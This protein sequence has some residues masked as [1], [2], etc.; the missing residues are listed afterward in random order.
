MLMHINQTRDSSSVSYKSHVTAVT[1]LMTLRRFGRNRHS[2][3]PFRALPATT[4]LLN[5]G[6][7]RRSP[8][9]LPGLAAL[10]VA[11]NPAQGRISPPE[12]WHR[13]PI[14]CGQAESIAWLPMPPS[15][16]AHPRSVM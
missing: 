14:A 11:R 15:G 5:Q 10:P 16:G 7:I 1:L 9:C 4:G 6:V 12:D 13:P 8:A 3:Q 2:D